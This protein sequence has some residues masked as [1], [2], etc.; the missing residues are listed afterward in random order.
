MKIPTTNIH[1]MKRVGITKKYEIFGSLNPSVEILALL[2]DG[3]RIVSAPNVGPPLYLE[4]GTDSVVDKVRVLSTRRVKFANEL[5]KR[6]E[7]KTEVKDLKGL[8]LNAFEPTEVVKVEQ[9]KKPKFAF[10]RKVLRKLRLKKP[11]MLKGTEGLK[12]ILKPSERTEEL[13][14]ETGLKRCKSC[15]I[16]DNPE[17]EA[18][19]D[20]PE[21]LQR[22]NRPKSA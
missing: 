11:D 13:E 22:V 16:L 9:K 14:D 6:I 18:N 4:S 7:T 1:Y 17:L 19:E 20:R 5:H 15:V 2:P 3:I 12:S 21:I 8:V 10:M